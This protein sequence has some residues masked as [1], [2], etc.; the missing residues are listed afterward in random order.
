V[1]T[2]HS[3]FLLLPSTWVNATVLGIFGRAQARYGVDLNGVVV[4]SNHLHLL[5][6]VESVRQLAGFMRFVNSNLARKI[7]KHYGWRQK[8]FGRRYRAIQV[9]DE[10]AAQVDRLR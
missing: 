1:R 3:R 7:G 6:C 5:L 8:F 10:E 4:L 2:V 9:S